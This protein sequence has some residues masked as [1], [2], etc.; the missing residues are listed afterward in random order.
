MTG[1]A[2]ERERL[3]QLHNLLCS[4]SQLRGR[5][6]YVARDGEKAHSYTVYV[7]EVE[8]FDRSWKVYRR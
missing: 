8:S 4:V 6:H 3:C 7:L 1:Q 2:A 5:G